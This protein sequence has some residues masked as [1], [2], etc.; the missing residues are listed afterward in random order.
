MTEKSS[1]SLT[2]VV[3]V[4]CGFI[5]SMIAKFLSNK[6]KVITIDVV[7]QPKSLKDFEIPH[8]IIDI[9]NFELLKKEIGTPK[10]IIHTAII[11]IPKIN[12][13]KNLGYDVNIVGTQNLCEIVSSTPEILGMIL[14]SFMAYV[15]RKRTFW[16]S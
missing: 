11:Q 14:I 5:G 8:K 13:E 7:P 2:D 12:E 9:K 3:I 15:W 4:G 10:I 1:Y 6:L 16:N